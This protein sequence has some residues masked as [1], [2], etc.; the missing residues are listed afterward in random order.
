MDAVQ[1]LFHLLAVESRKYVC[2]AT[3]CIDLPRLTTL[4]PFQG[5]STPDIGAL[6]D[7]K[8]VEICLVV[9]ALLRCWRQ[10]LPPLQAPGLPILLFNI[11]PTY[12]LD[13]DSDI[14]PYCSARA[15]WLGMTENAASFIV[16]ACW[17]L[18]ALCI[19]CGDNGNLQDGL[20]AVW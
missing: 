16:V 9:A 12:A 7:D 8:T 19:L 3:F 14:T 1:F 18:L 10:C 2:F 17:Q 15:M 5:L 11:S 13:A 4:F 6:F 20:R